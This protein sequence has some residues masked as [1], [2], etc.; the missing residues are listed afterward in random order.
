MTWGRR[1]PEE[2]QVAESS[3]ALDRVRHLA[4]QAAALGAQVEKELKAHIKEGH[5]RD[6]SAR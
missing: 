1:K 4:R 3:E 2:V 6:Q 5:E